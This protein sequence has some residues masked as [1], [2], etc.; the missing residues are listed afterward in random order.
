MM[1]FKSPYPDVDIPNVSLTDFVLTRMKEFGDKAALIDGPSGRTI[2]YSQLGMAI[3]L[4]AASLAKRGFGKGDVLAIYSPNIPEYA[5]AFHAVS[6]LGGIVTTVNPLY[7]ANELAHQLQ[8][9]N[10]KYLLTISIFLENAKAAVA[11]TAVEE[12][13]TFDPV[14]GATPFATLLQSDG[15]LPEVNIDPAEDIVVLPYSSGTTGLPKGVMLTH[16]NIV[17]NIIQVEGVKG[18]DLVTE[19]D[20]VMGI[21]PFFHIYG[22]VVI[23]NISLARGATVVTMPRFDMVQFLELIQKHKITRA[24]LVPP[25]L[26][27]LAKHPIVDQYDVSSLIELFS[28]AAPLGQAL[29]DEVKARL[30][31]RVVQGYGLTETSPVTHVYNRTLTQS[32]KLSSV[33]P[34]IPN[35][36]VMIADVTTSKPLGRNEN[37]EIWM[38]GPQ[39]MKGYLNNP[40]ATAATVDEDGWLHSGDI[41]YIDDEGFFYI[42]DRLKELIKYKGF[43]VAPAE[44]EALLLSHPAIADVAVIPSP[45]EEAG[46]VPKAFVVLKAE[47]TA[48]EIMAWVAER[49]SPQKKVRRLEFVE[50]VP[51]SLSGKIL[52]RILVE[53]ERARL[54]N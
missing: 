47:A 48:K 35:T 40:D 17:A 52:R 11:N 46:E 7:T 36:E 29:A 23:M 53:Q 9:S 41:G 19:E 3:H 45:D 22:M 8:D 43:Q 42:V 10:A 21:L 32:N 54:G 51:K 4:I 49:V 31:C 44:L 24:N 16:R 39:I 15:V 26:V 5:V 25:I 34:A 37:G 27:G 14:D 50:E 12:I 30:G 13:F 38:R 18:I 33:G 2:T 28:G 1:I 6:L 20:S